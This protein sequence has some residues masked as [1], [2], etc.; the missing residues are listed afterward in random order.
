MKNVLLTLGWHVTVEER[1]VFSSDN[2]LR[3]RKPAAKGLNYFSQSRS[4]KD[5]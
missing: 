3:Q 5:V 4:R 1:E 2:T